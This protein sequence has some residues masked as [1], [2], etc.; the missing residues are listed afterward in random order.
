MVVA[1]P[2]QSGGRAVAVALAV[3]EAP[4]VVEPWPWSWWYP[5]EPWP[6]PEGV[7]ELD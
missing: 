6:N 5:S 3:A 7:T 2:W 1:E 4:A